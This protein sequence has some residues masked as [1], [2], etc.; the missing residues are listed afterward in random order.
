MYGSRGVGTPAKENNQR[1]TNISA[2]FAT[3]QIFQSSI[4]HHRLFIGIH[5]MYQIHIADDD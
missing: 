2:E 3:Y 1:E 4:P 5:D